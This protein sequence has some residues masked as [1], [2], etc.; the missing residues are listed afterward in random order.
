MGTWIVVMLDFFYAIVPDWCFLLLVYILDSI[1]HFYT[2]ALMT[3]I[4]DSLSEHL[5]VGGLALT[6]V[7]TELPGLLF[8][9]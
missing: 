1:L 6:E 4:A 2:P 9:P 7:L 5:R 8:R 3:I